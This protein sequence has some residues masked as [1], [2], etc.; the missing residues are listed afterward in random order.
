M[1]SVL[2]RGG[3]MV[4]L[5]NPHPATIKLTDIALAL[6]RIPRWNGHTLRPWSVA[7]HS[8]LVADLV[9]D[10]DPNLALAAL[11]HDAHEAYIGDI[12]Q[13]VQEALATAGRVEGAES[14]DVKFLANRLNSAIGAAFPLDPELFLHDAVKAADRLALSIEATHLMPPLASTG[15][16]WLAP[17]LP[18]DLPP[19][20]NRSADAAQ[21]AFL[22]RAFTLLG[23]RHGAIGM[24]VMMDPPPPAEAPATE[25]A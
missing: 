25:A 13:P 23:A 19:L 21:N 2:T 18:A 15:Q 6:S 8:L 22:I 12:V 10:A 5:L 4:D 20:P 24:R 16:H 1:P 9:G 3:Q 7:D 17:T 11:L 14:L